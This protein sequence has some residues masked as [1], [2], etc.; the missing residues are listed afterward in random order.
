MGPRERAE[1]ERV[2]RRV[3]QDPQQQQGASLSLPSRRLMRK[4]QGS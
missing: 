2:F 4:G 3:R 1:M